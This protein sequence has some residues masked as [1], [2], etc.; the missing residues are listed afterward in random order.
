MSTNFI[1]DV[2]IDYTL[3]SQSQNISE[4]E[5]NSF[6][7]SK[8][9]NFFNSSY[10]F[11]QISSIDDIN[12]LNKEELNKKS[13]LEEENEI[14]HDVNKVHFIEKSQIGKENKEE[15]IKTTKFTNKISKLLSQNEKDLRVPEKK[16]PLPNKKKKRGKTKKSN[17]KNNKTHDIYSN[18]NMS[19]KIRNHFLNF[20]ILL[21]NFFCILSKT[22]VN[23]EAFE[24]KF[25]KLKN[26]YKITINKEKDDSLK[27]QTLGEIVDNEISIKIKTVNKNNNKNTYDKIKKDELLNELFSIKYKHLFKIYYNSIRSIN[28]GK[29][30]LDNTIVNKYGLDHDIKLS[31]K[32]K[33]FKDLL[34]N[35]TTV[36]DLLKENNIYQVNKYKNKIN[37]YA[38]KN[39]LVG[40]KFLIMNDYCYD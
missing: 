24:D 15:K 26:E 40:S 29:Y 8:L 6:D 33:M 1:H 25:Y 39:Y 11:D 18:Y 5:E 23:D 10:G 36:K 32:I 31:P 35:N 3:P 13:I 30:E 21:A 16:V 20:C 37:N 28:L 14:E 2:I 38:I 22:K 7:S 27:S 17:S 9:N 4:I 19:K 34:E 12:M